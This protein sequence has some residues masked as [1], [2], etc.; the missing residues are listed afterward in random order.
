MPINAHPE[1]LAAEKEFHLAETSEEKIKTLEKMISFAPKH[2]GAE[3]LRSQLKRR[4]KKL[5]EK[6]EKSKSGQSSKQGIKKGELQVILVGKANSGKSSLLNALTNAHPQISR[7]PYST[8]KPEIGIAKLSNI[9]VQIIENPAIEQEEFDK[10]LVHTADI[11]LI[12]VSSISEINEIKK[13]LPET[14]ARQIIVF[15]KIDKLNDKEK[16]KIK[17]T[18]SSKK[19]DFVLISAK[20]KE[21]LENL[22]QKII[23]NFNKIRVYT[24][25]PGKEK[26]LR[27]VILEKNSATKDLA[28]K[29]FKGLSQNIKQIKIWGPSSKFSGQVVGLKHKLKDLDT[30]EFKTG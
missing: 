25:E 27:P 21:N 18:L 29:I 2:K 24:K 1:Y 30:V 26:S 14:S 11:L 6:K 16:R 9:N 13:S 20:T 7:I 22:K 28:E 8:T 17:A 15:N 19:Y 4:L 12:L 3:N 5:K 10:G 23:E